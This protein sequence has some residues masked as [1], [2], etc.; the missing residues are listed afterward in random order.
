MKLFNAG[1]SRRVK[2]KAGESSIVVVYRLSRALRSVSLTSLS[3]RRE[4][5][6]EPRK[7]RVRV[8]AESFGDVAAD[9]VD[10]VFDLAAILPATG[11]G[12]GAC[13]LQDFQTQ[14]IGKLPHGQLGEVFRSS[15]NDADRSID[16]A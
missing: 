11:I 7:L 12:M 6:E 4:I 13:Q 9:R 1:V 15:H 5:A 16:H 2:S 8:S 14:R 3:E 10:G